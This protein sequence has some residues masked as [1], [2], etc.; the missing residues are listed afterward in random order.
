MLAFEISHNGTK[1]LVAGS[2]AIEGGALQAGVGTDDTSE[3]AGKLTVFGI[4][5]YIEGVQQD[6]LHWKEDY[7]LTVGD[8]IKIRIVRVSHA[9]PPQEI[10]DPAKDE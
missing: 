8:E 5:K 1:I 6:M 10:T 9:D 2:E 4:S 7:P 3:D